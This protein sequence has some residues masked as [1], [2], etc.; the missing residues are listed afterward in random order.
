MPSFGRARSH[1]LIC[2]VGTI[3][4]SWQLWNRTTRRPSAIVLVRIGSIFGP[5]SR[6]P[7]M[8]ARGQERKSRPRKWPADQLILTPCFSTAKD[9]LWGRI[10]GT[11][12]CG[13]LL[14]VGRVSDGVRW[15]YRNRRR[16][17]PKRGQTTFSTACLVHEC[18]CRTGAD[19]LDIRHDGSG[20]RT[21]QNTRDASMENIKRTHARQSSALALFFSISQ[22]KSRP[23]NKF[24]S[25]IFYFIQH[26]GDGRHCTLSEHDGMAV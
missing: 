12:R 8:S 17:S 11:V 26:R 14:H 13:R 9:D 25:S 7:T 18:L 16:T 1:E 5:T 22:K 19:G 20:A 4:I 24:A 3:A 6:S 23:R 2:L 15:L 10:H 21:M